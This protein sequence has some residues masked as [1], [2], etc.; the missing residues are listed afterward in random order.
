[1]LCRKNIILLIALFAC[2]EI[3]AQ[4]HGITPDTFITHTPVLHAGEKPE[5]IIQKNIF[6]RVASSKKTVFVGEPFLVTYKL[7][8]TLT[9]TSNIT[10]EPEF[11]GCSVLELSSDSDAD[12]ET[13]DGKKYRVLYIRKVQLI[14]LTEGPLQ[15]DETSVE[16]IVSFTDMGDAGKT[17]DYTLTL[18]NKPLTVNVQPLPD[19]NKPSNFPGVL[20]SFKISA[21]TDTNNAPVGENIHLQVTVSG[22]GNIS[23]ISLP[24]VQWPSGIE[25]FDG[26]DTQYTAPSGFPV[27]GSKT[28]N[29]PFIGT[30][31]GNVV[32]PAIA[33]NFFDPQS[34]NYQTVYSKSIAV[35]ITKEV[36]KEQEN[37]NII[38][39]DISNRRYLWIVPAIAVIVA[40]VF[41]ISNRVNRKKNNVQK[42]QTS[43]TENKSAEEKINI[44]EPPAIKTDFSLALRELEKISDSQTFFALVKSL[45]T[46]ALQEKLQTPAGTES[47]LTDELKRSGAGEQVFN[48]AKKIYAA[49]DLALY[50]P[51]VS[52]DEK[53]NLHLQL[54]T[55]IKRLCLM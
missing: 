10:K 28:F 11:S 36:P 29:L 47:Y 34:K 2:T 5:D 46:K 6:V 39:E 23:G 37:K 45:L 51:V 3:F 48:D 13:V 7:Y 50:S 20:G 26:T 24:A 9:R 22:S 14:P 53:A 17:E 8:T 40:F 25:H 33:F 31:E 43:A 30:K 21:K 4:P 16:N 44:N 15:L 1:M 32:I 19:N 18:S 42:K 35:S 54:N 41:I 55:V 27:S 52:D 38:T 12:E 49:C